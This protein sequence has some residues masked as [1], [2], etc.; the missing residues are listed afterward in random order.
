MDLSQSS[1]AFVFGESISRFPP[2]RPSFHQCSKN[3]TLETA[4]TPLNTTATEEF[5]IN[6]LTAAETHRYSPRHEIN[7]QN[8]LNS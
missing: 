3:G 4:T 5:T 8:H 2:G 1:V 7:N 6:F